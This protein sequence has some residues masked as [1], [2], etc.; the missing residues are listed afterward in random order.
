MAD[1]LPSVTGQR[2]VRALIRDGWEVERRARHG[3]W[4]RK[5]LPDGTTRFTTVKDTPEQVE[6]RT[7]G[8]I[9]SDKQTGLG[10]D[11]LR[12]ILHRRR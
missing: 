3:L 1:N 6:K 12:R 5:T 10:R 4:L 8:E 11:G 2:L 7:L 9:I